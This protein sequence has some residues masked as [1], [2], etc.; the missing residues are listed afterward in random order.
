M[1]ERWAYVPKRAEILSL[2]IQIIQRS[3][4]TVK[5]AI[6]NLI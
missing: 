3:R 4:I 6:E 1:K 2:L 5:T